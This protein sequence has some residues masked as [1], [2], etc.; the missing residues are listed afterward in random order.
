MIFVSYSR[1]NSDFVDGLARRL[2]GDGYEVWV[3]RDSIHR[4][5]E[6]R[7]RHSIV[8]AI[9]NCDTVVVILSPEA[10]NSDNVER[11]ITVA[12]EYNK[13]VVPVKYR[14]CEIP[15]GFQYVLAGLQFI[16]F[17]KRDTNSAYLQLR[18]KLHRTRPPPQPR[19]PNPTPEVSR[20][21]RPAT[22]ITV[23]VAC[24]VILGLSILWFQWR[25]PA[26]TGTTLETTSTSV[27]PAGQDQAKQVI[28]GWA[29]AT[30]NRDWSKVA[31]IDP[32]GLPEGRGHDYEG[33]Y[34]TD[35]NQPNYMN[36]IQPYFSD[37]QANGTDK[38]TVNGAVVAYDVSDESAD[39]RTNFICS[40]WDVDLAKKTSHWNIAGSE[41]YPGKVP[42]SDFG[43]T[44]NT[45]CGGR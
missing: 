19:P 10:V 12:A 23:A 34:G 35:P 4:Q 22:I 7:W 29:A 15:D 38:W 25:S 30:S 31:E 1:R 5:V 32:E 42:S 41:Q 45:V 26:T 33:W 39:G 40:T 43:S 17:S 20:K 28:A 13:R 36:S 44:Y 11:E 24:F 14:P 6:D 9:R 37:Q 3:D 21:V 2:S 18:S 27:E 8:T 16:D